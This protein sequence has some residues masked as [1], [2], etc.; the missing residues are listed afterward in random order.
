MSTAIYFRICLV[1]PALYQSEKAIIKKVTLP[2]IVLFTIGC[3]FSL[4]L[5]NI[6]YKYGKSIG[7]NPF[8]NISVFIPF[9]MQFLLVSGFSYQLPIIICTIT[10]FKIVKPMF[11]RNNL[12]YVIIIIVIFA[13]AP[14]LLLYLLG[15]MFTKWQI[16]S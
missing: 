14:M 2:F 12:R 3:L 9:I 10:Q 5:Y 7:V 6:L 15:M 8:F 4:L 13:A 16:Q 1:G 11:W